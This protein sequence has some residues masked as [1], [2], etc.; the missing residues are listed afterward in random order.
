M[1][2]SEINREDIQVR[3][4]TKAVMKLINPGYQCAKGHSYQRK[5]LLTKKG[6]VETI[7]ICEKCKKEL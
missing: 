7:W 5:T 1:K 2:V 4:A 6:I 3:N